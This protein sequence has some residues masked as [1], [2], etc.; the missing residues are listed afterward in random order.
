MKRFS[1]S[2]F[3]Q[4]TLQAARALLGARLTTVVR[5]SMT[6]GRIVEVEAYHGPSDPAA[7]S[8]NGKTERNHWMFERGG[9]CYVYRI[10][11]L[12]HCVNVVT[13]KTGIGAAV[14]IRAIEPLDGFKTMARR[15]NNKDTKMLTSG[16][17]R[18][19]EALGITIAHS[20]ENLTTSPRIYLSPD[21]THPDK[22][23][24]CSSRIGISK[25]TDLPWRLFVR[26]SRWISRC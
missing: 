26:S 16:P 2:F 17:A 22:E 18:L 23:I 11:G 19:C 6:S 21:L 13:E 14:L 7:H 9:L 10:Y 5:G 15:R 8:F 24:G 12:H 3:L 20:G 1:Q 4:P 25:G